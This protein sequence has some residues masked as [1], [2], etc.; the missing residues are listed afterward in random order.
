M[1]LQSFKNSLVDHKIH[2]FRIMLFYEIDPL[3]KFSQDFFLLWVL[4]LYDVN[5]K[6]GKTMCSTSN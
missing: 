4:L 2:L 5:E 3:I 6:P 1:Y